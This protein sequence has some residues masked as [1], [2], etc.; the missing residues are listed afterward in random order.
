MANPPDDETAADG[1]PPPSPAPLIVVLLVAIVLFAVGGQFLLS[2][3]GRLGALLLLLGAALFV[4]ALLYGIK[5]EEA[6]RKKGQR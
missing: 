3:R 1:K 5:L 4:P 2:Y 6:R